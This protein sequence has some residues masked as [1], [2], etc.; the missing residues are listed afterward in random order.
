MNS[1]TSDQTPTHSRLAGLRRLAI[2][3]ANI[4]VV[5]VPVAGL[6]TVLANSFWISELLANLRLQLVIAGV[7]AMAIAVAMR[8]W[9]MLVIQ[10]VVMVLHMSWVVSVPV[11]ADQLDAPVDLSV[12]SVN[13]YINNREYD[14][15]VDVLERCDAD[16]FSVTELT[17]PLYKRLL[18]E[19]EDSYP[20]V[21]A[22]PNLGAFGVAMFSKYPLSNRELIGGARIG[23][24]LLATVTKGH[25]QFRLAASHPVSPMTPARF[26]QRNEHLDA[27][28]EAVREE[29]HQSAEVP[30]VVMGDF[31]MTPWSPHFR[32]FQTLSG[33]RHV[34]SGSGIRPTWYARGVTTFPMGLALDHCLVSSNLT[35][36][37]HQIGPALGSDHLPIVV[38]LSLN[39][40]E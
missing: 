31:N 26:K 36:V 3:G 13:V 7:A 6:L 32:R 39:P 1:T 11:R 22:E 25:Q 33:L 30:V 17:P 5:G 18:V 34:E 28:S 21:V 23:S 24:T 14:R 8:R 27:L 38:K 12:T 15:I 20:H 4:F 29:G 40:S 2:A 35:W 9:K 16:V 19:F 10:L 37:S